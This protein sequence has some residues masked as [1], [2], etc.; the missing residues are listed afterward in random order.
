MVVVPK[1][2]LA[3]LA[4]VAAASPAL[5]QGRLTLQA[6]FE[7]A[8]APPGAEIKLVVDAEIEPGY[9]IYGATNKDQPTKLLVQQ[10]G[11]LQPKGEPS[12]PL[13]RSH[14][15]FGE[16]SFWIEDSATLTQ[17]FVVPASAA[18]GK[19]SVSG[20][21]AHMA[22]TPEMCDPPAKAKWSAELTVLGGA[23]PP[24]G[25]TQ[26]PAVPPPGPT[27]MPPQG[28]LTIT[29]RFE[30]SRAAPG[31]EIQLIVE[32][33]IE[34]GYHIYGATNKDQP[35]KLVVQ[36]AA[37]L[38]AQGSPSI[39]LGKPHTSFGEQAFWIEDVARITQKFV[40]PADAANGTFEVSGILPHMACT[41]EMCDPPAK[42]TWKAKFEIAGAAPNATSAPTPTTPAASGKQDPPAIVEGAKLRFVP[43]VTPSPARPGERVR[44][45]LAVTVDEGHHVYGDAETSAPKPSLIDMRVGGLRSDGPTR[46]PPGSKHGAD[47]FATYDLEGSFEIKQDYVVPTD[48]APGTVTLAGALQYQVCDQNTCDELTATGFFVALPIEAG[49]ARAEHRAPTETPPVNGDRAPT[50]GGRQ[51]ALP[52]GTAERL[53]Q[54]GSIGDGKLRQPRFASGAADPMAGSLWALILLC[55]GGGLIALIMPCTYPMIPITFSFFTKQA[56]ARG[57]RVLPLALTYGAGIVLIFVVIGVVVGEVITQFAA[58]WA[59]NVVIGGAFVFFALSLFGWINLQPPAFLM[60]AAGK[61]SSSGGLIGV[62]LMGATLVISS[63]TCTAP[64]VGSLL[65]GVGNGSTSR[66]EVAAGM[67]AFGLTMAAPFVF[68]ALLPGR[69][70]ALPRSGEWMNTLKVSLGFIELAAALK[71]FSNVDVALGLHLCPREVFL[72]AWAFVFVLLALFLFGLFKS[73]GEPAEGVSTA[74]NGFGIASLAFAFYCLFGTMG[75]EL[76]RVMTAFEPPYRLRA[77][78]EHEIV[79]DDIE[80]ALQRARDQKKQLL[81]NFTGFT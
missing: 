25:P 7:P 27:T 9:H 32:A 24:P 34:P 61:A 23:V 80:L 19:L 67:A 17:T 81:V 26:D 53:R 2:W 47:Q 66:W 64:I 52:A 63:F 40:V 5:A 60:S 65:A 57:G 35:T 21:V 1:S 46:M 44:L 75:F 16:K 79:K 77:I 13:G 14:D 12:V 6:R 49:P 69:V 74:R 73:K 51:P 68:L 29:S 70:K 8:S 55:I 15:S 62:F 71:F 42:A 38:Q 30:P 3:W 41:P 37:G 58:H 10:S 4:V 59:T 48:V 28:R 50:D 56:D 72:I 54:T 18:A 20:V 43:T 22:C 11:G 78:E 36:Q 33:E 39:P 76:D 31:A 45:T